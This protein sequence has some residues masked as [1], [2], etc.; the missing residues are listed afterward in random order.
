MARIL[1]FTVLCELNIKDAQ[2]LWC[3]HNFICN[4]EEGVDKPMHTEITASKKMM[5]M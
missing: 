2:L 4:M 3:H 5:E 1:E